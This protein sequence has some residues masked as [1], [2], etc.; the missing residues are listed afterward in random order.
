MNNANGR[1]DDKAVTELDRLGREGENVGGRA[2]PEIQPDS[3]APRDAIEIWGRRI[4]RALGWAAVIF[5][6]LQLMRAY[7]S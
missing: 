1:R 4:G 5:L 7:G 2:F 6:L 3:S